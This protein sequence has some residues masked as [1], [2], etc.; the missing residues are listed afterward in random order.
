M[1][2]WTPRKQQTDQ[3]TE[4]IGWICSDSRCQNRLELFQKSKPFKLCQL[5][6]LSSNQF[7]TESDRFDPIRPKKGRYVRFCCDLVV[8]ATNLAETGLAVTYWPL[9]EVTVVI[10]NLAKIIS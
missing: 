4:R 10:Q 7:G 1:E 5:P 3:G 9:G 8:N 6:F 2:K